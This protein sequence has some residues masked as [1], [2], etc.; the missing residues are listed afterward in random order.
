[1]SY[2]ID[3]YRE[4]GKVQKNPLNV[5]L[6][7]MLFPQL[8]AG[9]IVRYEAIANEIRNRKETLTD[10]LAGTK[11]F[12]VG[13]GKKVILSNAIA[14]AADRCFGMTDYSELSVLAAWKKRRQ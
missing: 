1:M 8:I 11:R 2:V 14:V 12:I 5:A 10:L 6:Y 7:I 3:I 4:K 9:P 13:L